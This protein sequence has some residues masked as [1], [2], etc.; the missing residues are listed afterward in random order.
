MF[1]HVVVVSSKLL[2]RKPKYFFYPAVNIEISR[3]FKIQVIWEAK[4]VWRNLHAL[5]DKEGFYLGVTFCDMING[6]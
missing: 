1:I 6:L 3:D 4:N 5:I 2:W